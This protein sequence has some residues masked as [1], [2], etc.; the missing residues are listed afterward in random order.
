M[1][2]KDKSVKKIYHTGFGPG[3]NAINSYFPDY[4]IEIII[5]S[6][7][8]NPTIFAKVSDLIES[9]SLKALL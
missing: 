3:V 4:D 6:N 9:I 5:L 8:N 1:Y 2:V 7:V